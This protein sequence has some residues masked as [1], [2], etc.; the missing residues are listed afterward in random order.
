MDAHMTAKKPAGFALSNPVPQTKWEAQ[1]EKE[2]IRAEDA[3]KLQAQATIETAA[4]TE[5]PSAQPETVTEAKAPEA[6]IQQAQAAHVNEPAHDGDTLTLGQINSL[7]APLK[8]D[9]AGLERLG[10]TPSKTV[11]AAKHYQASSIP[12]MV[13][14]MLTHLQGVLATA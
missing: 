11:K 2:R 6:V 5:A 7:I 1:R 8:V 9:A 3:A 12:A 14:A 13:Q 4:K 10:F